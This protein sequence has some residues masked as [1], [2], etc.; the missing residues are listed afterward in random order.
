M[1]TFRTS[2]T[3][4]CEEGVARTLSIRST[5]DNRN[6]KLQ[7]GNDSA[8]NAKIGCSHK[9]CIKHRNIPQH[10]L[11]TNRQVGNKITEC[12]QQGWRRKE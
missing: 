2:V 11:K 10:M 5:H 7:H 9:T 8:H 6:T 3:H 4:G 12:V 1:K